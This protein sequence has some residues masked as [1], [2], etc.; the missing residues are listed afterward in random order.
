MLWGSIILMIG[1]NHKISFTLFRAA[2]AANKFHPIIP[3][4]LR[5]EINNTWCIQNVSNLEMKAL[6]CHLDVACPEL[7]ARNYLFITQKGQ[8]ATA[9][10]S[11]LHQ[12]IAWWHLFNLNDS[13][14]DLP[15]TLRETSNDFLT[16]QLSTKFR[17]M[18]LIPPTIPDVAL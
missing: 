18:S 16:F 6:W 8:S 1:A 12:T 3:S 7:F 5:W 9:S 17:M 15:F 13:S 4:S 2:E 11:N 10:P 14:N